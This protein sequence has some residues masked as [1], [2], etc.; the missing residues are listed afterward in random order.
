MECSHGDVPILEARTAVLHL[1]LRSR[2]IALSKCTAKLN[3]DKQRKQKNVCL[4]QC[5]PG[6]FILL[7]KSSHHFLTNPNQSY[8]KAHIQTTIYPHQ[9]SWHV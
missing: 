8:H 6:L 9:A 3:T 7:F 2:E 1:V 5:P 4:R